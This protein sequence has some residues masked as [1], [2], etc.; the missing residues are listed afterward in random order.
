M[1]GWQRGLPLNVPLIEGDNYKW[2]HQVESGH[3]ARWGVVLKL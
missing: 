1:D 3:Y 2:V